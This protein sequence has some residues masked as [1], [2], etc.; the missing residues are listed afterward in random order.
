M[1]FYKKCRMQNLDTLANRLA[2]I[3]EKNKYSH[4]D[5]ARLC[6]IKQGSV[7]YILAKNLNKSKLSNDIATGLNISYE[8]LTEGLGSEVKTYISK[9]P[10]FDSILDCI[11]Y[12][13]EPN[14]VEVS[15]YESIS[16]TYAYDKLFSYAITDKITVICSLMEDKGIGMGLYL[17]VMDLIYN[18][19]SLT[20]E[21]DQKTT[22]SFIVHELRLRAIDK[23]GSIKLNELEIM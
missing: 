13:Q 9:V 8:W 6:G 18:K 15:K 3:M 16:I 7:S 20:K 2:Y 19:I 5:V 23:N 14:S 11:K 22:I 1:F 10:L 21:A 17:N 12:V 4:N